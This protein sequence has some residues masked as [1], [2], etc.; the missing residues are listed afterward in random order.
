M[1]SYSPVDTYAVI[2]PVEKVD[3]VQIRFGE[4]AHWLVQFWKAKLHPADYNLNT[5]PYLTFKNAYGHTVT[6]REGEYVVLDANGIFSVYS[7]ADFHQ[8]F[9]LY[10]ESN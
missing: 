5:G 3:S 4:T 9:K 6:G 2:T 7:I 1:R 10:K 8:K